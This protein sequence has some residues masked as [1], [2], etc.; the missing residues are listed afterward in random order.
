MAAKDEAQAASTVKFDP[1]RSKR[2]ATRPAMTLSSRPGN[3]SSVHS[4][5]RFQASSGI[6]S[7][8]RGSSQRVAYFCPKSPMPP[9]QPSM[10][11]VCSLSKSPSS[12]PASASA[13]RTASSASSCIGSI[14]ARDFGGMPNRIGSKATSSINPPQREYTLSLVSLFVS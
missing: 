13:R 9:P 11:L 8:V 1:P 6:L 4:G 10:T 3:D 14:E 2:L 7:M 12:Q 5:N